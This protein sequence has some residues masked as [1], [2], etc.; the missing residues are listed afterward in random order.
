MLLLH[1]CVAILAVQDAAARKNLYFTHLTAKDGLPDNAVTCLFQDHLN[2]LWIGTRHGLCRYDGYNLLSYLHQADNRNSLPANKISCI[3]GDRNNMLWIATG[4]NGITRYDPL[5]KRFQTFRHIAGNDNSLAYDDVKSLYVD[6]KNRI[7]IGYWGSGW[8]VYDQRSGRFTHYRSKSQAVNIYGRN[9]D[10]TVSA[11]SEDKDGSFWLAS[12]FGLH[13][14]D[15]HS[16]DISSFRCHNS[17]NHEGSEN[18]FT[19]I[20][21]CGDSALLLGTWAGG[22]KKFSKKTKT[23]TSYYFDALSPL[24]GNRNII[25]DIKP[26]S[27]REVWVASADKGLGIFNIQN[28]G[29]EFFPND[30]SN[31]N[32]PLMNECRTLLTDRQGTLW[33]GFDHGLS[34][35]IRQ[36]EQFHFFPLKGQANSLGPEFISGAFYKDETTGRL[37]IGGSSGNGIYVVDERSQTTSEIPLVKPVP[38]N[39]CNI[40]SLLPFGSEH[41]LIQAEQGLFLLRKK[42]NHVERLEVVDQDGRSVGPGNNMLV[43]AGGNYWFEA[44]SIYKIDATLKKA[45]RFDTSA[46]SPIRLPNS[47][48]KL[49]LVEGDSLVWCF[50]LHHGLV[51]LHL[52][53]GRAEE[54]KFNRYLDPDITYTGMIRTAKGE[55]RASSYEGA[56]FR[57]SE[58]KP[59]MFSFRQYS[60]E[61]GVA[62][63]FIFDLLQDEKQRIWLATS[64]GPAC[65]LNDHS[66]RTF[67]EDQGF[68]W[69]RGFGDIYLAGDNYIYCGTVN[70]FVR[71]HADSVMTPVQKP[72]FVLQ[73]FHVFDKDWNDSADLNALSAVEL[74]HDQNFI[75]VEFAA[76]DYV[77]AGQIRYYCKLENLNDRWIDIGNRRYLSYSGLPPGD[78][79]LRIKAVPEGNVLLAAERSFHILIH[80]PFWR[81]WWFYALVLV[82]SLGFVFL[83]YR[84]RLKQVKHE[85]ALKTAFNK[86]VAETEMK[87]LRAQMNP[88]FIFNSLNSINRYIV[89]SD[90]VTA[91]NYL[92][93]FAKL[94]RLILDSSAN[95]TTNLEQEIELLRLYIDM[96]CLRFKDQFSY[97]LTTDGSVSSQT[98]RIPSMIIQPYIENAIWHG[99]LHKEEKGH[100]KIGFSLRDHK[101]AVIIEDNGIGREKAAALRSRDA[102]K[103]KSYGLRI[104][105]DR[106]EIANNLYGLNARIEIEDLY[107]EN[108]TPAGT[109]VILE[110][111]LEKEMINTN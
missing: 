98:I 18:L 40:A 46:A 84:Y 30:P 89:K 7:W 111:P 39:G 19:C 10:N 96:E 99:L 52:K 101:L 37:Y 41:L 64:K 25:L 35:C 78:Y 57:F 31:P 3:A 23:F 17:R 28:G 34:K 22:V 92:T 55:Y 73:S 20:Y 77:N 93:K 47:Y 102:L 76:I 26:R 91:S 21:P 95:A 86:K 90:Q 6:T 81:T 80:P 33:A 104:T 24:T 13:H 106:I 94:I 69:S 53:Q 16:G 42:D 63:D 108:K 60:V 110:I 67:T 29:F 109:R 71:F 100:L 68:S 54:M 45:W 43:D 50:S 70:G 48:N 105:G 62:S 75:S 51:R 8:S 65:S 56:L 38:A 83:L 11:F 88:H 79:V 12:E 85:E 61:E 87:A 36:S 1:L 2:Y 5:K 27:A 72:Q 49:L 15:V 4:F 9:R 74:K 14:L 58:V 97:E 107:D 59:G 44:G 103:Q 82:F 32:S 66:F